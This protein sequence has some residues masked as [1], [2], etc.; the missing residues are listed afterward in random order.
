[1]LD[2]FGEH[3]QKPGSGSNRGSSSQDTNVMPSKWDK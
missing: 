1:M 3:I 2:L